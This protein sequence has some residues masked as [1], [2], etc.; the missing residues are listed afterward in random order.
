V[1]ARGQ[2]LDELRWHWGDAYLIHYFETAGK[3]VAQRRDSHATISAGEPS[4]LLDLI[5][6]DYSQRPVSRTIATRTSRPE[7]PDY[8]FLPEG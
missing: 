3:W 4:G 2:Q 5:R 1:T 6:R 8:R 7:T